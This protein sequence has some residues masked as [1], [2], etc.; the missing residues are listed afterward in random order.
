MLYVNLQRNKTI[1]NNFSI[2]FGQDFV[3]KSIVHLVHKY[4]NVFF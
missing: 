3:G 4:L 2:N 1:F